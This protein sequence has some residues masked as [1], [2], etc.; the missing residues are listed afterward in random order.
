MIKI[1]NNKAWLLVKGNY[2]RLGIIIKQD[3]QNNK[4]EKIK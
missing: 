3:K 4:Q 1:L 2:I